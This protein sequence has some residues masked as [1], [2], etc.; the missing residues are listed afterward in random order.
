MHDLIKKNEFF[1]SDIFRNLLDDEFFTDRLLHRRVMPPTN[2]S[3]NKENY[4]VDISIPG[5]E[6][7]NI[8]VTY[9]G[10]ILTISYEQKKSEEHK[11]KNY[12]RREFECKS[13]ARSFTVPKN[14]DLERISSEYKDGILTISLPKIEEAKEDEAI[15]IEIK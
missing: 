14:V 12:H 15:D 13:F 4:Q 9:K 6:K 8:K 2:V 5:I 10:R 7:E 11:E 1:S 3:E